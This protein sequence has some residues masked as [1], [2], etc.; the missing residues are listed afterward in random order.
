MSNRSILV[1][2]LTIR[3]HFAHSTD[4]YYECFKHFTKI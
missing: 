4:T 3:S 1:A 2:M